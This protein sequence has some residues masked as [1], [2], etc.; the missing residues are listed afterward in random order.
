VRVILLEDV[1]E[2][3]M[4]IGIGS[5]AITFEEFLPKAQKVLDTVKWSDS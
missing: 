3:T 5:P 1:K 2:E 4:T